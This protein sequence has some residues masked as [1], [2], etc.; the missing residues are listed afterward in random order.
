[1]YNPPINRADVI[2]RLKTVEPAL[3]RRGVVALYLFGSHARD[4][5]R[6][7]SDLDVFVDPVDETA[8]GLMPFMDTLAMLE[9]T[10]PGTEIGYST[11]EGIVPAYLPL[12][13][14]SA[15]RVF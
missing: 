9:R 13:E 8:F 5:A 1:M 4:E 11:R 12:I 10:F 3:R 14:A 6:A 15:V 7:G 2:S